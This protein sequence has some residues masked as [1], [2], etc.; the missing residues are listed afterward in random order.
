MIYTLFPNAETSIHI[1]P[2][3]DKKNIVLA[4]GKSIINKESNAN[5]A[6]IL[7]ELG[8]GGHINAGTLQI[9]YKKSEETLKKIL[10]ALT[11]NSLCKA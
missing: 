4:V 10:L 3:K 7:S 11:E 1:F 5:L 9:E 8:G 2:A 6:Q